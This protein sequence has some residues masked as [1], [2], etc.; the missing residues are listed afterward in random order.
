MDVKVVVE[1][2]VAALIAI[3]ILVGIL[4][5]IQADMSRTLYIVLDENINIRKIMAKQY[6]AFKI[7]FKTIHNIDLDEYEGIYE[8]ILDANYK[9]NNENNKK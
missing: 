3:G 8:S 6:I 7:L 5:A 1:F 9:N 4:I 2:A